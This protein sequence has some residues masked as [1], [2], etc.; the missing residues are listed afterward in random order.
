MEEAGGMYVEGNE[1]AEVTVE[2]GEGGKEKWKVRSSGKMK[3]GEIIRAINER[4]K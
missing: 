3:E 4:V 2:G 1:R